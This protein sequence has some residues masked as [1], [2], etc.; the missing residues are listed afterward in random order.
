MVLWLSE[1]ALHQTTLPGIGFTVVAPNEYRTTHYTYT[2]LV[3]YYNCPL[4]RQI[5]SVPM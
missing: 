2:F 5:N 1:F 3:Q 4:P